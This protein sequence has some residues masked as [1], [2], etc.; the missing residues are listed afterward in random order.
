MVQYDDNKEIAMA[1]TIQFG[2]HK[3]SHMDAN[4]LEGGF[5]I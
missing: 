1:V 5:V 2:L 4:I 3:G